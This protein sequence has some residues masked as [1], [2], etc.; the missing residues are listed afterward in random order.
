M[1]RE[2]KKCNT[3]LKAREEYRLAEGSCNMIVDMLPF[4][5]I[6]VSDIRI[7]RLSAEMHLITVVVDAIKFDHFIY[8]SV[9]GP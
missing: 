3:L 4:L 5:R 7:A 8:S 9:K 2:G 6:Q 1:G